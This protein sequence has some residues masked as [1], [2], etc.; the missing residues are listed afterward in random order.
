MHRELDVGLNP[1]S[2]GSHPGPKAGAKLLS[3]PGIPH[4]TILKGECRLDPSRDCKE[5]Q[6]ASGHLLSLL[7]RIEELGT[8]VHSWLAHVLLSHP[9][10]Q[11]KPPQPIRRNFLVLTAVGSGSTFHSNTRMTIDIYVHLQKG[12]TT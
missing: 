6:R 5:V 1:G 11:A 8:Q 12:M 2:P 3:H 7:C 10:W 4:L 9:P